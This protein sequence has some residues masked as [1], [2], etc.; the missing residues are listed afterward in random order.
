MLQGYV[1]KVVE[2]K[3]IDAVGTSIHHGSA[4]DMVLNT[5]LDVLSAITCGGCNFWGEN[6][7]LLYLNVFKHCL[8]AGREFQGEHG[9]TEM[10][11]PPNISDF[12]DE[13]NRQLVMNFVSVLF[14][15]QVKALK[16]DG[17]ICTF[18]NFMLA[19]L[20]QHNEALKGISGEENMITVSLIQ[21]ADVLFI[22]PDTLK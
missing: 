6:H 10:L 9:V 16:H 8:Y 14:N 3:M 1:G 22:I 11:H 13:N 18:I 19:L 20:L 2:L 12:S 15:T 5:T 17:H 7:I 4:D 21:A